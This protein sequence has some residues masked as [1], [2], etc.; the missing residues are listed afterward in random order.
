VRGDAAIPL[1]DKA[2]LLRV[3]AQAPTDT[4]LAVLQRAAEQLAQRHAILTPGNPL[5]NQLTPEQI[6]ALAVSWIEVTPETAFRNALSWVQHERRMAERAA[7]L[8]DH[9]QLCARVVDTLK[10]KNFLIRTSPIGERSAAEELAERLR[11]LATPEFLLLACL[12]VDPDCAVPV[13]LRAV[14]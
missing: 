13:W 9:E 3:A 4:P 5:F 11:E 8:A 12:V 1:M 14:C 7:G 10:A 2:R 6:G